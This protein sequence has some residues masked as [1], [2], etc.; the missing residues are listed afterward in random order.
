LALYP[1]VFFWKVRLDMRVKIGLCFLMG[2]G[3]MYQTPSY[4]DIVSFLILIPR[5]CACSIIKTTV[6]Y[7]L[8]QPI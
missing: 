5:A 3:V 6:W 4:F 1:I 7:I 8:F 2:L